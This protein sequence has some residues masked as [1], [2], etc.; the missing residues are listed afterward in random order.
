[1]EMDRDHG[2]VEDSAE[3]RKISRFVANVWQS[4]PFREGNTRTIAV[5][6]ELYLRSLGAD[7]DN[8]PFEGNGRLFRDA[9]VRAN[10]SDLSLG[11]REET[12]YLD[13]FLESVVN[14]SPYPFNHSDLNLHGIRV[15]GIDYRDNGPIDLSNESPEEDEPR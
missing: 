9:L 14:G 6:T 13:A 1:M 15:S 10:F 11:I 8:K 5:F 2:W 12:A 7:V 4:H 3:L